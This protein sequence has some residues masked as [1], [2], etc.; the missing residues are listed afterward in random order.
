ASIHDPLASQLIRDCIQLAVDGFLFQHITPDDHYHRFKQNFPSAEKLLD[1]FKQSTSQQYSS[2]YRTP[3]RNQNQ[4]NNTSSSYNVSFQ[5]TPDNISNQQHIPPLDLSSLNPLEPVTGDNG[6]HQNI[7]GSG[8]TIKTKKT[9][10]SPKESQSLSSSTNRRRSATT[11]STTTPP[12]DQPQKQ[13][14]HQ[15]PQS[16]QESSSSSSTI[17]AQHPHLHAHSRLQ[18]TPLFTPS[19]SDQRLI[20]NP[21]GI[22]DINSNL[23]IEARDIQERMYAHRNKRSRPHDLQLMSIKEILDEKSDMQQELL[24]FEN[25]YSKP[26]TSEQKRIMKPLYD[27]YSQL[28]RRVEKHHAQL[29]QQKITKH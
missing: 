10:Y 17:L 11:K 7:S 27:Y 23:E 28:K 16:V 14:T 24:K 1:R 5:Q 9:V 18:P 25:K 29:Q 12:Y 3:L 21:A 20:I 8:L 22:D 2:S 6:Q 13:Q 4:V 26:K 15:R 19:P